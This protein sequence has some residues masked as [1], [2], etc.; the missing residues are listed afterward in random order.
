M[1]HDIKFWLKV[2]ALALLFIVIL[3]YS[4]YKTKDLLR[5]IRLTVLGIEDG[6]TVNSSFLALQGKAKN[7][8]Y[9]SIN[10]RE[11]VINPE[12]VFGDSLILSPGYNIITI[13][14]R[15]KFGKEKTKVYQ[16]VYK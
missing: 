8:V 6:E 5:G 4:Y 15:D 1:H 14:A 3:G 10:D 7:A 9:V 12:G 2:G 13:K 11:I 16:I